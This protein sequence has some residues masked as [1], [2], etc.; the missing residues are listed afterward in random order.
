MGPQ[1]LANEDIIRTR[2]EERDVFGARLGRI[3]LSLLCGTNLRG[4]IKAA[5]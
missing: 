3:G 5:L 1:N 2:R 4:R